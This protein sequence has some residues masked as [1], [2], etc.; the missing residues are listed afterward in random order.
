MKNCEEIRLAIPDY[1][2][3]E[4]DGPM[5]TMV[6]EHIE[7]CSECAKE[8]QIWQE[9]SL[10]IQSMALDE[11]EELPRGETMSVSVM[12]RI[13]AEESWRIPVAERLHSI[14]RKLRIRLLSLLS[15][16]L[17][18]FGC[19]LIYQML[20][21]A[22]SVPSAPNPGVMQVNALGGDA[23]GFMFVGIEGI[24]VASI[25]DP[26]VLGLSVIDS[27]PNYLFALSM[28]GVIC[29]LLTMNWLARIRA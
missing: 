2:D 3:K 14:P 12:E 7:T 22:A 28:L 24:P 27:Y 29:A 20:F 11:Q 16:C 6:D 15:G 17:A 18:M 26:L 13:Y 4:S 1:W 21:P 10:L 9:S 5:R 23:G 19:G 8:F 25:G